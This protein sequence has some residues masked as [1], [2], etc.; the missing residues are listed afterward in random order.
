MVLNY[1][2]TNHLPAWALF[3]ALSPILFSCK[4]GADLE[5]EA[6]SIKRTHHRYLPEI[7]AIPLVRQGFANEVVSN[8]I[9]EAFRKAEVKFLSTGYIKAVHVKNG[10][11]VTAGSLM[12]LLDDT[13]QRIDLERKKIEFTRAKIELEDLLITH[14][15]GSKLSDTLDIEQKVLA[16]FR[17]KSGFSNAR[18]AL[19]EAQNML[20]RTGIRAPFSGRVANIEVKTHNYSTQGERFCLVVDDTRFEV[21]FP[22]IEEEVGLLHT[23]QKVMVKP[24]S[25]ED[26]YEGIISEINPLVDKNGLVK[27]KAIVKN[28]HG[29]LVEGMNVR[30]IARQQV[31]EQLVIPKEALLLRDGRKV[32]FTL[33]D[34]IAYWNYV[35][36]GL[37]NTD[38]YTITEG[39][40]ENDWVIIKGNLHLAHESVVKPVVPDRENM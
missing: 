25:F 20:D 23:G 16:N 6:K 38:S 33:H 32:V 1:T 13:D 4:K 2:I 40:K 3:W 27:V 5:E 11:K 15:P 34:T 31:P 7:T 30:V 19:K 14:I 17:I 29:R 8:G 36:T 22:I 35:T 39:L 18:I 24:F 10:D 12:V 21:V 26:N 37:E 28:I 9:L